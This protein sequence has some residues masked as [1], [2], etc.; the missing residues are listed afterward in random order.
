MKPVR[1]PI[2]LALGASSLALGTSACSA[3]RDTQLAAASEEAYDLG[4]E[5][6]RRRVWEELNGGLTE[7]TEWREPL[8]VRIP[9]PERRRGAVVIGP[10]EQ[11]VVIRPGGWVE[12]PVAVG[13][14]DGVADSSADRGADRVTGHEPS[15]P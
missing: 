3:T 6:G 13:A 15:T 8:I 11:V 14:A 9:V 2:A 12:R 5:E 10:S 4:A 7:R 1:I